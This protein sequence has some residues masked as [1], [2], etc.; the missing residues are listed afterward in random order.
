MYFDGTFRYIGA[1]DPAPLARAV[2]SFGEAAW[3][4]HVGR[5]HSYNMHRGT[6]SIP[7]LYDDDGR[8]TQ[9]TPWPRLAQLEPLLEPALTIIRK[10]N[11]PVPG[12]DDEG[13][14][15]RIILTRLNP[16]CW[17]Y[18]HRDGGDTLL[19]SHRNHIAITTDQ[20]IEFE[21]GDDIRHLAPGEIWEINNREEHAVRN[22]TDNGRV[23]LIVDYVVPGE[24]IEDP[25]ER[26]VA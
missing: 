1:I 7:L 18:R 13:Y 23:H 15:I 16:H 9:P 25:E 4:E 8:H 24:I 5:Q 26:C 12:T 10:A 2:E 19:R 17:I 20:R 11:P 3:L 14:F 21:V 6:Q 22:P